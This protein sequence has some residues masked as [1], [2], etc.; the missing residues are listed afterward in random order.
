MFDLFRSRDKAV[1]ILLGVILGVVA[2]SMVTYLSPGAGGGGLSGSNDPDVIASIGGDTVTTAAVM[3][4]ISA[5]MRG[6]NLPPEMM[7]FYAPQV[8]EQLINERALAY[9]AKRLGCGERGS[10][11]ARHDPPA[12][13]RRY[14]SPDAGRPP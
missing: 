8:V 14:A 2:I 5:S 13:H 1:R 12:V 4:T 6:K 7:S 9:E 11:A 3:Q 10:R